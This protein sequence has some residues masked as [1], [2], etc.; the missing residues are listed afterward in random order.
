MV[1]FALCKI[2][3]GVQGGALHWWGGAYNFCWSASSIW[4][5][6]SKLSPF[7]KW[8]TGTG[9]GEGLEDWTRK[10]RHARGSTSIYERIGLEQSG[11]GLQKTCELVNITTKYLGANVQRIALKEDGMGRAPFQRELPPH[12]GSVASLSWRSL[13]TAT[14]MLRSFTE[15]KKD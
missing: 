7:F 8:A 5:I 4:V 13:T 12:T 14:G 9:K 10:A 2:L 1:R 11:R 3:L 6:C 15:R